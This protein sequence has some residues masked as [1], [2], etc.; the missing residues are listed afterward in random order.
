MPGFLLLLLLV[1]PVLPS[2]EIKSREVI[3][4]FI[5]PY[6]CLRLVHV[7]YSF[8][9]LQIPIVPFVGL[10]LLHVPVIAYP[11]RQQGM[12]LFTFSLSF[13][14]LYPYVCLL[15]HSPPP[16]FNSRSV[17]FTR[18]GFLFMIDIERSFFLSIFVLCYVILSSSA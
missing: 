13:F 15:A 11:N 18:S 9:I 2:V 3:F 17:S 10:F 5:F 8:G 1:L 14:F 12:G 4:L 6:N 7:R 16:V